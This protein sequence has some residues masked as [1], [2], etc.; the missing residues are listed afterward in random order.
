MVTIHWR[1]TVFA[2]R[3]DLIGISRIL[4]LKSPGVVFI[5]GV[6]LSNGM[7]STLR[8]LTEGRFYDYSLA[9]LPGDA[10]IS[11]ELACVAGYLRSPGI[12][13][14]LHGSRTW[15]AVTLG[16]WLAMGG[17]LHVIAVQKRGGM[18]TAA[19]TYHNLAVVP[20]F[21]YAVLSTAPLLWAMKSRRAGGWAVACLVGWVTLL[22]ID[23]QLGNL[24]RNTPES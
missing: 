22:V 17:V 10:L 24:S 7:V 6:V 23:I 15:H 12:R 3:E 16:T 11:L 21:G 2:S 5:T 19:N 18:E 20:L 13:S 4:H 8:I 14:D 9:S 1:N